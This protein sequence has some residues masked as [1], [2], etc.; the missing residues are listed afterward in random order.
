MR[1][2]TGPMATRMALFATRM[3]RRTLFRKGAKAGFVFFAVAAAGGGLELAGARKAF[4]HVSACSGSGNQGLGC[5][6]STQGYPCGPSRCCVYIRPGYPSSC[7]CA[8][9]G[10]GCLT[11]AHCLGEETNIYTTGCWTCSYFNAGACLTYVTTCCD[12]GTTGCGD[13]SGRCVSYQTTTIKGCA[14]PQPT[15]PALAS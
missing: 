11:N 5:P 14:L 9:T 12:C 4:A 15:A 10:P 13:S 7:D 1:E 8:T 2:S 3:D 6:G